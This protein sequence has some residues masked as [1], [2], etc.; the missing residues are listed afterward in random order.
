MAATVVFEYFS[1]A[2]NGSLGISAS[3]CAMLRRDN[4]V[5]SCCHFLSSFRGQT[6]LVSH[7]L[8]GGVGS[9]C[10]GSDTFVIASRYTCTG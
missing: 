3:V 9:P 7:E 10:D 8:G 1:K 2:S 4:F 5:R 6:E